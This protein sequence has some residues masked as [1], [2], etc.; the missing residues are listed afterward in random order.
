MLLKKFAIL[1]LGVLLFGCCG[2]FNQNDKIQMSLS[3]MTDN[4]QMTTIPLDVMN[5]GEQNTNVFLSS[6]SIV[7]ANGTQLN[8]V[9]P[10]NSNCY[11]GLVGEQLAPGAQ[12]TMNLC[13]EVSSNSLAGGKLHITIRYDFWYD[14]I[15][16]KGGRTTQTT[17]DLSN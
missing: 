8:R 2:V 17:Y 16:K 4:G 13:Y 5:T 14:G 15:E 6:A 7:L 11:R 12:K 1:I 3:T 10:I 9:M